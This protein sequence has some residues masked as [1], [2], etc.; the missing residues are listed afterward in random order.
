M[1]LRAQQ[2]PVLRAAQLSHVSN[3]SVTVT[4]RTR[5]GQS[6]LPC[7]R[8]VGTLTE[9][10]LTLLH[11]DDLRG[12]EMEPV[13]YQNQLST[14]CFQFYMTYQQDNSTLQKRNLFL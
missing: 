2:P 8:F 9:T 13:N 3:D 10:P 12:L 5:S 11:C 1:C 7:Q 6:R 14:V 4:A